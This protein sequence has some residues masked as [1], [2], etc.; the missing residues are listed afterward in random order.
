[1]DQTVN[2]W[3]K[4]HKSTKRCQPYNCSTNSAVHRIFLSCCSPWVRLSRLYT[5]GQTAFI[6]V[7]RNNSCGHLLANRQNI[8]GILCPV[9]GNLTYRNQAVN[10]AK[11]NKGAEILNRANF[12]FNI[13][14]NL[15]CFLASV[16]PGLFLLLKQSPP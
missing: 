16:Y 5:Q 13:H 1:M 6:P 7:Q 14:P 4:V 3:F 12:S 11:V 9:P 2:A 10:P 15:K 8:S